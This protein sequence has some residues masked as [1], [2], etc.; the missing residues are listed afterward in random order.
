ML[1]SITSSFKNARI[2]IKVFVAPV[3]IIVFMLA[4]AAAAQY[5]AMQQSAALGE[6]ATQT[7]P[8][9]LAVARAADFAVLA[10]VDLYRT[11]NWAA[12]SDEKQKF[13]Q[14]TKQTLQDI[15]QAKE[16]LAAVGSRWSLTAQETTQLDAARKALD[17]YADAAANVLDLASGDAATAFVF[18]LAV[19]KSFEILKAKLDELRNT[20]S[21]QT[22]ETSAAAF[23]TEQQARILFLILLGVA[24]LL[25][26]VVTVSV[27]RMIARPIGGMTQ[28]MTALAGGDK[29]V[30]IPGTDRKD[31]IGRMA[32]AVQVFKTNMIEA[33]NLAAQQEAER[34]LKEERAHRVDALTRGFDIKVSELVGSVSSAAHEMESTAQSMTSIANQADMQ[35]ATVASAAEQASAN[36]QTVAAAAQEL[37]A[38]IAEIGQRV[39]QSSA[40]AE[41]AVD[42]TKR[43]DEVVRNLA[44]SAQRI[45]DVVTLIQEI[46]AQTNL[47]ALNATIEAARAGE[48]GKGFA[49]VAAEVKSLAGQTAKATADIATQI[50]EIQSSTQQAVGA[51]QGFGQIIG[52]IR[53]IS[54]AIASAIHQ[55]GAATEQI[56]LNAQQAATGTEKVT[57]NI[58]GVKK[59]AT[60]T[61]CAAGQ[62][63]GAA[64][65]LS[66]QAA[67]LTLEVN[68]F[69]TGVRAA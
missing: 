66:Q 65:E 7:M 20:Q 10:H 22:D 49:V 11:I 15:K 51:I 8:K 48:L 61:G 68:E 31:E 55:Q 52:D 4:M 53:E 57:E 6:F 45:G 21:I 32:E 3:L 2:S 17:Q 13:E 46:A 35:S 58:G 47:L 38:S 26:A 23:R 29:S 33:E 12:N 44:Q 34:K 27:A 54:I 16:G 56:A 67:Q 63:L 24:L 41:K 64:G 37:S 43:T 19:D 14:S 59:A 60:E 30:V 28:A 1:K 40:I 18:V 42:E 5:G 25:A 50:G 69:L 9:S 62:V 39:A 36:V